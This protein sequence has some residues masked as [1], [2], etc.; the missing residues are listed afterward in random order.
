MTRKS[1]VVI[2]ILSVIVTYISAFV[3]ALIRN[4]LLGGEAG[5]PFKFSSATMFG[6]G[7]TNYLLMV[8]N[9]LFWFAIIWGIGRIFFNKSK[10]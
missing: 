8:L 6:S 7:S 4:T 2:L 9:I 1:F 10:K 5:F 3:D